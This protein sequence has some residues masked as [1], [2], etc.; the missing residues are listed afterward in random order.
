MRYERLTSITQDEI[1][2]TRS[3]IG[4]CRSLGHIDCVF[5]CFQGLIQNQ[6]ELALFEWRAGKDPRPA[7]NDCI[8]TAFQYLASIHEY[9]R[10]VFDRPTDTWSIVYAAAFLLDRSFPR[11]IDLS[12][13]ALDDPVWALPEIMVNA[14]YDQPTSDGRA[15][16]ERLRGPANKEIV[17]D[18]FETYFDLLEGDAANA[19]FASLVARAEVNYRRRKRGNEYI[20]W[21]Y[22]GGGEDNP[23]VVDWRLAA[24]L[25]KK[26]WPNE[27]IHSW[28]WGS[29]AAP[30]DFHQS[31][32]TVPLSGRSRLKP[33]DVLD[34]PVG[35]LSPSDITFPPFP[36]RLPMFNDVK[37]G[38]SRKEMKALPEPELQKFFWARAARAGRSEATS[39][40]RRCSAPDFLGAYR[41][42]SHTYLH[43]ATQQ[44]HAGYDPRPMLNAC[45][46][47]GEEYV[48]ACRALGIH[49]SSVRSNLGTILSF[50]AVFVD[51]PKPIWLEERKHGPLEVHAD[52]RDLTIAGLHGAQVRDEFRRLKA[53]MT[54]LPHLELAERTYRNYLEILDLGA[55]METSRVP[56]SGVIMD[57]FRERKIAVLVAEAERNFVAREADTLF[58]N[59][60]PFFQ[61]RAYSLDQLDWQL[62][63]VL[64]KAGWQGKSVHSWK[65]D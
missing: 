15:I 6:F 38:L 22:N 61:Y 45:L 35:G 26:G 32:R 63:A 64:K 17:C 7:L 65:W 16:L 46:D 37:V 42:L 31:W 23:W 8:D 54:A 52:L 48:S 19:D 27:G 47:A 34:Q 9:G 3:H 33:L 18:T 62:A 49:P 36:K 51:R 5:N 2:R 44:W 10:D 24:I 4:E 40:K 25:K 30:E 28:R 39:A 60:H 53:K 11:V 57:R 1:H 50:I 59:L 56:L 55:S 20:G 58:N 12:G 13:Q 43:I 14:L 41:S 29:A 21:T